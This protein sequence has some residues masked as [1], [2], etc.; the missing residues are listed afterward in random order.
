MAVDL[1][2]DTVTKPTPEM[3]AAMARADLGDDVLGHDPTTRQLEELAAQATGMEDALFVPSGTMGNQVALAT[4]THPGDSVLFDDDAHMV[5]YEV[6]APAILSGVQARTVPSTNGVIDSSKIEARFLSKSEHTPGTTLLC[7]ENTHNR[8]GG[9]VTPVEVHRQCRQAAD[10]LG[11]RIHLDGARVFNA[12]VALG[13]RVT[14]ITRHVD[15]VSFCLSKGLC[16]P[17]GSVLCGPADFIREARFWRKR[18]GGGLR[19]SGILAACGIVSLTR[20]VDRLA[21]DHLRTHKLATAVS[22][23]KGVSVVPPQTNI[24]MID[25]VAP[26]SSWVDAL[27]KEGVWVVPTGSHRV[28]AVLHKDIGDLELEEALLAFHKVGHASLG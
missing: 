4:H 23:L 19:Q 11:I 7:M 5:Y 16:S 28:R 27:E 8:A 24:L 21:E 1:R 15:T 22:A 17:V 26:A 13:V 2:S 9:T 18:L 12:A 6:G 25:T 20:M 14:E 3:Y 10:R